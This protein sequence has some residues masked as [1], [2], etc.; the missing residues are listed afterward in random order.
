VTDQGGVQSAS[1]RQQD[2]GMME[3]RFFV[4]ARK[5]KGRAAP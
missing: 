3:R 1:A 2:L 4:T 5:P